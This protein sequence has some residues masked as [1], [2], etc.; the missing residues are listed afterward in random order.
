MQRTDQAGRAAPLVLEL[1]SGTVIL[2]GEEIELPPREFRLLAALARRVGE[3]VSSKE[4]MEVVWAED[5]EWTPAH[6]LIVLVSKLR[7]LLDG[8]TKFGKN[9]RNR[10]SRG[11]MLDLDPDQVVIIEPPTDEEA[12]E[13]VVYLDGSENTTSP[14]EPVAEEVRS[15]EPPVVTDSTEVPHQ[16]LAPTPIAR[17]PRRLVGV[18][19]LLFVL[20]AGSWGTGYV[21]S[22]RDTS[23]SSA[24]QPNDDAGSQPEGEVAS[25]G[26]N[27][28][29]TR[30]GD[31]RQQERRRQSKKGNRAAGPAIAAPETSV[32]DIDS[33][34]AGSKGSSG[35]SND[36]QV[37]APALP[38]APTRYLYHLVNPTSG[39]H[40]VTTDSA[41]ASEQEARGYE[42]GPIGRVYTS[43]EDNTKAITTNHG[44]AYIFVRSAPKTEPASKT[45]ALWYSTNGAGDFFYTTSESQAT[46]SGW[47]GSIIGYVR[48]L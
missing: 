13:R 39:D 18:G 33:D 15:P 24:D 38:P 44:T 34:P 41:T 19:A 14:E 23:R 30:G 5:A 27:P 10:R 8:P 22:S 21:L 32:G 3:P 37:A 45:I 36:D 31:D 17:D 35:G 2:H 1:V 4:L 6:N 26:G 16:E 9:I 29:K 12:A 7:R 25:E 28:N 42:G 20:L 46:Q 11:Y 47:T 48:A 43:R 40:F